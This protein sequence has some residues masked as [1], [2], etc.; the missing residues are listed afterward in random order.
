MHGRPAA[1]AKYKGRAPPHASP[2]YFFPSFLSPTP[3]NPS[4]ALCPSPCVQGAFRPFCCLAPTTQGSPERPRR[5][6]TLP[7][8]TIRDDPVTHLR[9]CSGAVTAITSS[10]PAMHWLRYE[11]NRSRVR[12]RPGSASS[13]D[14]PL[15]LFGQSHSTQP[16][17]KMPHADLVS[18]RRPL[19]TCHD[20]LDTSFGGCKSPG[21]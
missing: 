7:S 5:T 14:H 8:T 4:L 12:I 10:S 9:R 13:S 2:F 18:L 15:H 3:N 1:F 17:A 19:I 11:L 16:V 20:P 21:F 6:W